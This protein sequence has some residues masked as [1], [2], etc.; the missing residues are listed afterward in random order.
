MPGGVAGQ[1]TCNPTGTWCWAGNNNFPTLTG[2]YNTWLLLKNYSGILA[3][4][5]SS[6]LTANYG[7]FLQTCCGD[8]NTLTPSA[9]TY[10]GCASCTAP[11]TTSVTNINNSIFWGC[12]CT[13]SCF[14]S[15]YVWL[16]A[17]GWSDPAATSTPFGVLNKSGT[18]SDLITGACGGGLGVG[19]AAYAGGDQAWLKCS[20]ACTSCFVQNG[21]FP[22]G[23][24][25]T[26][27]GASAQVAGG[28]GAPGLVLISW[29]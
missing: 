25:M 17:C 24:G 6:A 2:Q 8:L 9:V 10:T 19:G 29:C 4:T 26:G 27:W 7:S 3:N 11:T 18:T 5:A 1:W 16:G 21:N 12:L 14:S 28:C 13:C 20:F 22:G 15:P 23:G